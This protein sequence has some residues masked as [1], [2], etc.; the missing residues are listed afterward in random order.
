LKFPIKRT[1]QIDR[2]SFWSGNTGRL[3]IPYPNI[4]LKSFGK[5]NIMLVGFAIPTL[6]DLA[7]F[8]ILQTLF[9]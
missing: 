8:T 3:L 2:F 9:N 7:G 6:P 5:G 1:S 4:P